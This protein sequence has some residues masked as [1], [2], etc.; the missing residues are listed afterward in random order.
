MHKKALGEN[1]AIK[2]FFSDIKFWISIETNATEAI[3]TPHAEAV[4]ILLFISSPWKLKYGVVNV[5]PPIPSSVLILPTNT[6][7]ECTY[8]Y[9][10]LVF[11]L[12][13]DF[14]F[15]TFKV[16]RY[17]FNLSFNEWV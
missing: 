10:D 6:E 2:L 3:S 4:A 16:L 5:P 15:V 1:N 14:A 8:L 12:N 17:I 9:L 11:G 7:N 13:M